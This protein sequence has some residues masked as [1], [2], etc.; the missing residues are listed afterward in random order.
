V[1]RPSLGQQQVP[2]E[3]LV[4]GAVRLERDDPLAIQ[5]RQVQMLGISRISGMSRPAGWLNARK[6]WSYP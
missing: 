2:V 1:Q 5:V 4:L 3:R 6:L